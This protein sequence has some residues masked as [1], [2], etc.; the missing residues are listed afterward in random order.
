MYFLQLVQ[1][2]LL[3]SVVYVY[4]QK[5]SASHVTFNYYYNHCSPCCSTVVICERTYL[6]DFVNNA[7]RLSNTLCNCLF[8]TQLSP[9]ISKIG[10]ILSTFSFLFDTYNYLVYLL[11]EIKK[12]LLIAG[13]SLYRDHPGGQ[14][15]ACGSAIWHNNARANPILKH[16]QIMNFCRPPKGATKEFIMNMR[17]GDGRVYRGKKLWGQ[18]DMD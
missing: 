17:Y 9:T 18:L 10:T 5:H 3:G 11:I 15:E 6:A 16:R 4:I 14:D 12:T 8:N 2:S 13:L 1:L 7:K